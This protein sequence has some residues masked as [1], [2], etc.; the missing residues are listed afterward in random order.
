M[1]RLGLCAIFLAAGGT[2]CHSCGDRDR[3][4][5]LDR[6]FHRDDDG[7]SSRSARDADCD[8]DRDR[9]SPVLGAPVSYT[10]PSPAVGPVIYGTDATP[11]PAAPANELPPPTDQRIPATS[12]PMGLGSGR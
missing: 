1:R 12:V 3:P 9:R 4:R 7:P 6:L 8:R 2:G 5:L 11:E 10:A